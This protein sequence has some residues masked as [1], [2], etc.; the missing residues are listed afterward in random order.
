MSAATL[1]LFAAQGAT[2]RKNL[3]WLE[4][5][6]VTP[7]DL[8]TATLTMQVR[9]RAGTT[10]IFDLTSVAGSGTRIIITDAANG[11]FSLFIDSVDTAAETP[12]NYMYD[13]FIDDTDKERV[14]QGNFA[15]DSRITV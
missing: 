5:D 1:N 7:I 8:T 11:K 3:Q 6:E 9:E 14:L 12:D 4:N 15:L 2:Y 10:L 13:L